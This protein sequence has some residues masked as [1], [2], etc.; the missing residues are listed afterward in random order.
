MFSQVITIPY[1]LLPIYILHI[2]LPTSALFR[3][4]LYLD[5][6]ALRIELGLHGVIYRMTSTATQPYSI[7]VGLVRFPRAIELRR[8]RQ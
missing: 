1:A 3:S 4:P 5:L 6:L 7:L 2:K 8:G